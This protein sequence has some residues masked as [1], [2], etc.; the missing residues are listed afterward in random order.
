M[1]LIDDVIQELEKRI[2]DDNAERIRLG[3]APRRKASIKILGQ[4]SL[5]M[6]QELT[7]KL[8]LARTADVDALLTGDPTVRTDLKEILNKKSMTYDDLSGEVWLP[9]DSVFHSYYDSPQLNVSY[10]DAVSALTSKAVKAKEKN[11]FL[12]RDALKI[13][14]DRLAE[15]IRK[16]GGDVEYFTQSEK[17]SL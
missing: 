16:Y 5:Q 2:A 13:Y 3:G 6:N 1:G 12:V 9:D 17:L 4:M 15:Q 10:L 11:R 14:G 8:L 7:D